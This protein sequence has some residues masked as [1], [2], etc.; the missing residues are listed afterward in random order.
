[1]PEKYEF[2]PPEGYTISPEVVEAVTPLLKE[3]GLNQAQA[4]KLMDFHTKQM[5]DAAK[6]PESTY[7][8]MRSD[9]QAKT[10]SDP[11]LKAAVSDNKTG[12]EAVK[13]DIGK[14][15][16][17]LGEPG[18]IKDFKDAMD[19]TGAGDHPAM[20]K[21]L[22]KLSAFITEGKHVAGTGPSPH[23]QTPPGAK[24]P[25]GAKAMYPNLP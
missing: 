11:D 13:L 4:Q 6:A 17:A 10:Q 23:G 24:P 20:I 14:A 3:M 19:L 12:L 1:V 22:W 18:L 16:N 21:T 8:T 15:L 7:A 9:W 25:S 2:T 5:I